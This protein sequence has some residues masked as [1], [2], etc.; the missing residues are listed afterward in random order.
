MCIPD[1]KNR[2]E[3]VIFFG[4][5]KIQTVKRKK[6]LLLR[7]RHAP[8]GLPGLEPRLSHTYKSQCSKHICRIIPVMWGC[9]FRICYA[10]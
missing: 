8:D 3:A 9:A 1:L 6:A 4:V 10:T 2:R 7:C 5:K